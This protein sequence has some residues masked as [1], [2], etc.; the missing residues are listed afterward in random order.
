MYKPTPRE[1]AM[2]LLYALEERGQ[3]RGKP[4]TRARLSRLTLNRLWNREQLNEAWLRDVNEWLLS[5]GWLVI[6][7]EATYGV[8]KTSVIENWPRVASKRIEDLDQV[9]RGNF[10]FSNLE[11]L[12]QT[13]AGTQPAT[14][15]SAKSSHSRKRRKRLGSVSQRSR[16]ASAAMRETAK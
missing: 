11:P 8:I 2:L 15:S 4:L 3:R 10:D 14:A 16:S 7:A 9:G 12:L 1:A 5:V 6:D 13:Q